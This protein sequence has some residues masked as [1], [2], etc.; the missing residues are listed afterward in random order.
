M[1]NIQR[2]NILKR[3]IAILHVGIKIVLKW[4]KCSLKSLPTLALAI[5]D[6]ERNIDLINV[7]RIEV[8][9]TVNLQKSTD[10]YL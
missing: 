3:P 7:Q 9:I 4:T 8:V 10:A 6:Q 5:T 2:E 1:W